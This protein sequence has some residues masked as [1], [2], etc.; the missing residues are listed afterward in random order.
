[1]SAVGTEDA[2]RVAAWAREAGLASWG[3]SAVQAAIEAPAAHTLALEVRG[4]LV[5]AVLGTLAADEATVDLLV[6]DPAARRRGWGR[7]ALHRWRLSAARAGAHR[8][9]LE[10]APS[11]GAAR[12]LYASAG[13]V[14]V[15][16]RPRYYADGQDALVLAR[17]AACRPE[18]EAIILA[19]GRATRLGGRAKPLLRRP[20][21]R[22]LLEALVASFAPVAERVWLC[23]PAEVHAALRVAEPAVAGLEVVFDLGRG[24]G[25]AVQS[26]LHEITTDRVIWS[27]ADAP[28]PD[29]SLWRALIEGA[30]QADA[31]LV[32]AE[33]RWQVGAVLAQTASVALEPTSSLQGLLRGAHV[34]TIAYSELQ[35]AAREALRDVDVPARLPLRLAPGTGRAQNSGDA[36]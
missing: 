12:S 4:R 26:A 16:A 1:M 33:G 13:F 15:G 2:A 3:P 25:E 27:V 8:L 22:T 6:V 35:P 9:V 14:E 17:A 36:A 28:C 18:L 24:P 23:A 21:G 34:H 7:R 32:E 19:G 20:D 29:V 31:A 10:V 5:A 30:E 11:N